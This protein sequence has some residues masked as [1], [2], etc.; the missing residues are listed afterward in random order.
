MLLL[1]RFQILFNPWNSNFDWAGWDENLKNCLPFCQLP[2][3]IK[4]TFTLP[5]QNVACPL[6]V[7]VLAWCVALLAQG[8]W[9]AV[10]SCQ[11]V[12]IPCIPKHSLTLNYKK[13]FFKLSVSQTFCIQLVANLI[14]GCNYFCSIGWFSIS[15]VS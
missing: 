13:C 1:I 7:N 8:S 3:Y 6:E 9:T 11:G 2:S 4:V 14:S 15:F 10:L 5:W 12:I